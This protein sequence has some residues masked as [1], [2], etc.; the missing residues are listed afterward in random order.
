MDGIQ[1]MTG[2][3]E[4]VENRFHASRFQ[5]PT[6]T[7]KRKMASKKNGGVDDKTIYARSSNIIG[8][9][10][11]LNAIFGLIASGYA[12]YVESQ[13]ANKDAIGTHV[14]SE[15]SISF[16]Q[17]NNLIFHNLFCEQTTNQLAISARYLVFI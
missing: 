8:N 11:R 5:R 6:H 2:I 12:Y 1:K 4:T 3:L 10:I 9:R 14:V 7:K 15:I 13:L 16:T 17:R